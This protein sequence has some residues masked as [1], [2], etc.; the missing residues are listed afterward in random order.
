MAALVLCIAGT[1]QAVMTSQRSSPG[2]SD[3]AKSVASHVRSLMAM[4]LTDV[5]SSDRHTV[6]PWFNGKVELSSVVADFPDRGFVLNGGRPDYLDRRAV[7]A[8]VYPF[9]QDARVA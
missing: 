4:H 3:R 9:C 1:W 7:A 8:L 2:G 6:N 5:P